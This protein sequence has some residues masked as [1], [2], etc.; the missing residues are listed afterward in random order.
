MQSSFYYGLATKNKGGANLDVAE[1]IDIQQSEEESQSELSNSG[2]SSD[3]SEDNDSESSD[4]SSVGNENDVLLDEQNNTRDDIG[5][6][7]AIYF[8]EQH[9]AEYYFNH[10]TGVSQWHRPSIPDH[11]QKRRSTGAS[12]LSSN[13]DTA[14]MPVS[15]GAVSYKPAVPQNEY[16]NDGHNDYWEGDDLISSDDEEEDK[17]DPDRIR[18]KAD[19][20]SAVNFYV[21]SLLFQVVV[22]EGPLCALEGFFKGIFYLA[23]GT[24]ALL[25]KSIGLQTSQGRSDIMHGKIVH[26]LELIAVSATLLLPGGVLFAYKDLIKAWRDGR[27]ARSA[28]VD[29]WVISAIPSFLG[30]VD[31]RKLKMI[32]SGQGGY[33]TNVRSLHSARA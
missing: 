33:A 3:S 11:L 32:S 12:W 24:V 19:I 29:D 2:A 30:E 17:N 28:K 1:A 6:G 23:Q 8:D 5:G 9:R 27:L 16:E 4:S 22:I 10:V 25:L 21:L 31:S 15:A 14:I 26:G 13:R 7:W 18:S 20:H